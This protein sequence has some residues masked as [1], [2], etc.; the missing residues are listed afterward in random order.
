[1]VCEVHRNKAVRKN[2]FRTTTHKCSYLSGFCPFPHQCHK[3]HSQIPKLEQE[4]RGK[5]KTSPESNS[6]ISNYFQT[7]NPFNHSVESIFWQP[8]L[9]PKHTTYSL[10]MFSKDICTVHKK[11]HIPE[12]I[13]NETTLLLSK[14][15]LI[16]PY[17]SPPKTR[18]GPGRDKWKM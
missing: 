14:N 1:M 11:N 17:P 3:I 9:F 8:P 13:L 18:P 10:N 5:V 12:K 15:Q 2:K 6:T 4:G 7:D 16:R